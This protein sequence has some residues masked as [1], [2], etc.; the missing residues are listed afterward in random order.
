MF[1]CSWKS[2]F[3]NF[4]FWLCFLRNGENLRSGKASESCQ[5]DCLFMFSDSYSKLT[6]IYMHISTKRR[7]DDD[8]WGCRW[9]LS[10]SVSQWDS[11]FSQRKEVWRYA[12][13]TFWCSAD[14]G[15]NGSVYSCTEVQ[16]HMQTNRKSVLFLTLIIIII[17]NV[18]SVGAS[19]RASTHISSSKTRVSGFVTL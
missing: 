8:F 18:I 17:F 6:N 12:S 10:S 4:I 1:W 7:I 2:L 11:G 5:C 19:Q 14:R 16:M 9:L 15:S 3:I 13:W